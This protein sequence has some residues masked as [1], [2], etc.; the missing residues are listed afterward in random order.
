MPYVP[1]I[2]NKQGA[3]ALHRRRN[4][5]YGIG[6]SN[7]VVL[8]FFAIGYTTDGQLRWLKIADFY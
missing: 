7:D 8:A 5:K 4:I 2:P 3:A 1:S 6:W